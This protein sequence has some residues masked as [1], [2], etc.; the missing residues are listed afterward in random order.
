METGERKRKRPR[1]NWWSP[2]NDFVTEIPETPPQE[3]GEKVKGNHGNRS[4]TTA[5]GTVRQNLANIV[6][7]ELCDGKNVKR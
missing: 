4:N 7:Q 2:D 6:E 3:Q 5:P 1:L